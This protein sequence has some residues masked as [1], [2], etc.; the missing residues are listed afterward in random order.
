MNELSQSLE[1]MS[2]SPVPNDVSERAREAAK[3]WA[4]HVLDTH[5]PPLMRPALAISEAL[6]AYANAIEGV[7]RGVEETTT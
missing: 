4:A 5:A 7:E 2:G 6:A 3:R 1:R